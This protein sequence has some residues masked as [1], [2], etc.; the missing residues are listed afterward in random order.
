MTPSTAGSPPTTPT[1]PTQVD[2]PLLMKKIERLVE[3]VEREDDLS[4]TVQT[5]MNRLI[6]EFRDELGVFGGRLY[7]RDG[8]DYVLT[9]T[10]GEAD[11]SSLGLEV[12]HTYPPIEVLLERGAVYMDGDDP[13]RD[14]ELE[15]RLGVEQFVAIEIGDG[16]YLLAFDVAPGYDRDDVV[17]SLGILRHT[18]NQKLRQE[19]VASVFNEARKIQAS[20]LPKKPPDFGDFE[21]A[22]RM[23]SMA[24][25]G[26]DLYDYIPVSSKILGLAI[27]DSSGHGLPAA[28]QV[29]DVYMGLRM[30]LA[31]DY[32]IV[33]TVERLNA[34]IHQST[35]TSRFVSLFYGELELDGKFIYVNA[36]HP[37]PFHLAADGAV[38]TLH[39]GGPVLGPLPEAEYERGMAVLAPGDML[40]F[41]TDG[42]TETLSAGHVTPRPEEYGHDRLIELCRGLCGRTAEEVADA[43]L[44]AVKEFSGERPVTDDRT[45]VV[46]RRPS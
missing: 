40:V 15:R 11:D 34:I 36:G 45:V 13:R 5:S 27:A 31:R 16:E 18:I 41:Y 9:S 29:R 33:R 21:I 44:D 30:G 12:P 28:L 22:G 32:K 1:P 7:H 6:A 25:V 42:V 8:E 19:R 2:Y 10:F 14:R 4:D 26:G 35:L 20:I 38:R 46:A 43:I 23:E 24:S 3:A 39:E 17:F 37:R